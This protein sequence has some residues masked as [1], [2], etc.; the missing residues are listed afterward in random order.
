[1][2]GYR[3]SRTKN[4]QFLKILPLISTIG[5]N[6]KERK[7]FFFQLVDR[8]IGNYYF[9]YPDS[10]DQRRIW[11]PVVLLN[12]VRHTVGVYIYHYFDRI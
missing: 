10:H 3:R 5:R 2:Y 11:M 4:I 7:T 12:K 1:M 6:L 9:R 8:S